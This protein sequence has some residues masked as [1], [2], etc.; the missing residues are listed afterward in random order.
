MHVAG[1][2]ER[3]CPAHLWQMREMWIQSHSLMNGSIYKGAVGLRNRCRSSRG[4]SLEWV[5]RT[6]WNGEAG[7]RSQKMSNV[8]AKVCSMEG[9]VYAKAERFEEA[10]V[11]WGTKVHA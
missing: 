1:G 3:P 2:R 9:T 10:Q 5:G 7:T 8:Q 11:T 4:Q 6:S